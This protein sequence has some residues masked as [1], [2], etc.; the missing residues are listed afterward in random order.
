MTPTG[1]G[2]TNPWYVLTGG[3]C[4]GKTTTLEELAKRGYP[5]LAEAAR[6][7]F[8]EGLADGKTIDELR[9][10]HWLQRIAQLKWDM[11]KAVPD[12]QVFFFDRGI[13]DSV[14]YYKTFGGVGPDDLLRA[15]MADVRY[16]KVFLLDLI[17]F[18][19]DAARTET[20]EEAM[21]LH[22]LIREAYL[23]QGYE[24]IEVPV[25]PVVERADYILARL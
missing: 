16:R 24:V 6:I 7:Y 13:P 23:D 8:E 18:E 11:E 2:D 19:K 21:I 17:D 12:D 10:G 1:G 3:P 14:A 25:I 5:V 4:A 9:E 15:A 20:P 22:G